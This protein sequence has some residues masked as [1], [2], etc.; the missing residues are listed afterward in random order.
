MENFLAILGLIT[1]ITLTIIFAICITCYLQ[2]K[3]I[4]SS[5]LR[6]TVTF[7]Y[8]GGL[9]KQ[10][11]FWVT[12]LAPTLLFI[13]FGITA[14]SGYT[15]SL[16]ARGFK[17]FWEITV[18]PAA[19]LALAVP[20]SALV[21]KLHS[22]AQTAA[23]I[24]K[25]N[26]DLFYLHR[27]EY[28]SYYDQTG[29]TKFS[30]GFKTEYKINPRVHARF[31]NGEPAKGTP[32]LLTG[33]VDKQI[34]QIKEARHNLKLV[35]SNPPSTETKKAFLVFCE[36]LHALVGF[37]SIRDINT[38]YDSGLSI[39][40]SEDRT[41]PTPG[42]NLREAVDAYLCTENY[43]ISTIEFAGYTAGREEIYRDTVDFVK[44]LNK[45]PTSLDQIEYL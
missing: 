38:L 31:F 20:L 3:K 8:E 22:T 14:W 21:A 1:A 12:I 19:I 26:H 30:F 36:R 9:S 6:K 7:N 24:E 18:L 40:I 41:V 25:G 29:A 39:R 45:R 16:D 5:T 13:A 11:I 28:V 42:K 15:L 43:L 23:Q 10:G 17:T 44:L 34:S 2:H 27:K 37:L 35:I 4:S 33:I 32:T